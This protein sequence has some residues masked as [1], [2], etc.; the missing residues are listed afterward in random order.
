MIVAKA[1]GGSNTAAKVV[2]KRSGSKKRTSI[3]FSKASRPK[4]KQSRRNYKSYRGQG[5][6]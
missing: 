2:F 5:N 6:P 1:K 3:G 4:N